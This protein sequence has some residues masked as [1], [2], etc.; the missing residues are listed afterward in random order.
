MITP[1][2][3]QRSLMS[4]PYVFGLQVSASKDLVLIHAVAD[5]VKIQAQGD[6]S[7]LSLVLILPGLV[8]SGGKKRFT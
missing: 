3:F 7:F 4:T 1:V 6:K 5:A 8:I 2:V